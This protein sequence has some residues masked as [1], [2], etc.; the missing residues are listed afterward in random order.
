MKRVLILG[1]NEITRR[2]LIDLCNYKEFVSD[3]YLASRQRNECD[4]LKNLAA[5]MGV[6]VTTSGIDVSNVEGAMMMIK[7]LAPDL[8]VNLLPPELALDAMNLAIKAKADYIDGTLFGVPEFPSATSLL[9]KQFER[10]S[11]FQSNAKT[12]VCGAGFVPG[13][14]TTII[15]RAAA[16]DFKKID[17]IDMVAVSGEKKPSPYNEKKEKKQKEEKPDIDDNL[18]SEDVKP[19]LIAIK[20]EA[21]KKAFYIK[22]GKAVESTSFSIEGRSASGSAVFLSSSP[23][24]TDL[25]KEI[26]EASNVRYFKL[27]RKPSTIH[28]PPQDK[29]DLLKELGLLSTKPVKVGDVEVAPVDLMAELLPKMSVDESK[30]EVETKARGVASYEIYITGSSAKDGKEITKSYI[31]KGDNDEAYEKY[32]V[33][34]FEVMKG[35]ALIAAVKLMCQDKWKKPGVF[36]PAA[37][38]ID[39]YYEAFTAEGI[40]VTEG[41]GKPF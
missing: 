13:A 25:I 4:E 33:N 17:S 18:Y 30:K 40:K 12:A 29:L 8:V 14:V 27:G 39:S 28:V 24:L 7:I 26:P 20:A 32:D 11:D 2:L 10:F 5:S 3:I 15:R 9:S 38:D 22:N 19:P 37:F 31:I 6:R 34:A 16:N 36:T 41:E 21:D 1:C 23:M 35:S